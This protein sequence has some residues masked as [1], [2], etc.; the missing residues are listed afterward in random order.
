MEPL[1][2]SKY[3]KRV[4]ADEM[5][6]E[7]IMELARNLHFSSYAARAEFE[8]LMNEARL[9]NQITRERMHEILQKLILDNKIPEDEARVA[10][11]KLGLHRHD[12]RNFKDISE[13]R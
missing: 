7:S 2:N 11:V 13:S 3:P 9:S 12:F 4:P 10:A 8:R 6:R 1:F 5:S